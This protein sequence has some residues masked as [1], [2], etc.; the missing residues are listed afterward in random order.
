MSLPW[1]GGCALPKSKVAATF[2]VF[3]VKY[4]VYHTRHT[5]VGFGLVTFFFVFL[6]SRVGKRSDKDL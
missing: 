1:S 3:F 6:V 4:N 2:V 5:F